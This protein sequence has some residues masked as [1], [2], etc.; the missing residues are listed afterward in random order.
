MALVSG[1]PVQIG[2]KWVGF[3]NFSEFAIQGP[4]ALPAGLTVF[5]GGAPNVPVTFQI[6]NDVVEGNYL[7]MSGQDTSS[8]GIGYNAFAG[9][10]EHGEMLA[11]IWIQANTA[12]RRPIGPAMN[13]DGLSQATLDMSAAVIFKR[14]TVDFEANALSIINNVNQINVSVDMRA[15]EQAG[16]WA[17]IRYFKCAG[18]PGTADQVYCKA[19]Y[20]AYASE[21]AGWESVSVNVGPGPR[22]LFGVGWGTIA[23]GDSDLQRIAFLSFSE[24]PTVN[25]VPP[26]G[27]SPPPPGTPNAP[28][29]TVNPLQDRW[30]GLNGSAYVVP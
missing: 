28:V 9:L 27:G 29:V 11:R 12:N 13:L 24:D 14:T 5:G 2:G 15:A 16:V 1:V 7:Q 30:V 25:V 23:V 18:N 10:I 19:W 3:T 26:P 21:P 6:A 8:W 22:G 4:G 17:W 20:G